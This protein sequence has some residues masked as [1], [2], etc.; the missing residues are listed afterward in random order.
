M[1]R[2]RKQG[3]KFVSI[4]LG[5]YYLQCMLLNLGRDT[6][7]DSKGLTTASSLVQSLSGAVGKE[8]RTA[9]TKMG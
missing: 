2:R 9:G 1:K 6:S 3:C 5:V 8:G 7:S 4:L